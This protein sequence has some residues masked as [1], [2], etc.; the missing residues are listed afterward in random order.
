MKTK[1]RYEKL[2]R[3][4][5]PE[6]IKASGAKFETRV[7]NN[8]EFRFELRKKLV[9]EAKEVLEE[10]EN[11]LNEL[12]DTLELVE[13]IGKEKAYTLE[14]I[15]NKQLDIRKKRGGFE[16]KLLLEWAEEN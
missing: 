16:K 5:I 8:E 3:D 6:I 7:L 2:I 4:K 14:D 9:E 1:I 11:L 15:R 12:A 10:D 13:S